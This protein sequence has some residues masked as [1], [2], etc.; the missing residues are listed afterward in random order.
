MKKT[1]IAA[2]VAAAVAAPAAFADVS[3]SG[4]INQEFYKIEDGDL[5][6]DRNADVVFKASEDLGNGMK[7]FATVSITM[8]TGS[9]GA[10]QTSANQS[11]AND[12]EPGIEAGSTQVVGLTGSFGTITM[13]KQELFIESHV[14]AMAANDASDYLTN[15][16]DTAIGT[17]GEATITY[18]SPSINGFKLGLGATGDTSGANNDLDDTEIMLE[19]S[20]G[21]L[22]ARVGYANDDSAAQD[23]TIIGV[24]YTIG[25]LTLGLVNQRSDAANGDETWVGAKYAMGANT[26]AISANSSDDSANDDKIISLSH[27]MSKNVSVYVAHESDGTANADTTLAGM[28]VKF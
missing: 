17:A 24:Q 22:L 23:E 5:S 1:I 8:D 18:L 25:D 10:G 20:N 2:A 28:A 11:D 3:V 7:A 14:A 6:S 13:G 26:L 12:E 21:P 9:D 19:Y 27:A 4:Q 15:E 16:V